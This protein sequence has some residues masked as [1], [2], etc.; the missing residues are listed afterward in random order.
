MRLVPKQYIH[1]EFID[2]EIC[3]EAVK[4][5][6]YILKDIPKE[7]IN[8]ELCIEDVK[9]KVFSIQYV[10]EEIL[11]SEFYLDLVLRGIRIFNKY[12]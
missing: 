1:K 12:S 3:L 8:K 2:K 9:N 10:P 6:G 4:N 7:F 11:N 5:D